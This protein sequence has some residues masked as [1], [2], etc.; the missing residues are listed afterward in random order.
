MFERAYRADRQVDKHDRDSNLY[1]DTSGRQCYAPSVEDKHSNMNF[2]HVGK[3][4]SECLGIVIQN[5]CVYSTPAPSMHSL[6]GV[7]IF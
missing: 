6:R 3:P 4:A 1:A 5:S 2:L 7:G